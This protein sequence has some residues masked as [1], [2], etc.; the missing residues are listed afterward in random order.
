[1]SRTSSFTSIFWVLGFGY[2]Q[3]RMPM[4][5]EERHNQIEEDILNPRCLRCVNKKKIIKGKPFFF[6]H[7]HW[8]GA[9]V[10]VIDGWTN[11]YTGSD[12]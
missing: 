4:D 6:L 2:L 12:I 7:H 10:D 5:G 8:P 3:Y 11:Q 9:R 1:M